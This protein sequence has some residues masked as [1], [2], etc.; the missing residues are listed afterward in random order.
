M[1][2][3]EASRNFTIYKFGFGKFA[4]HSEIGLPARS[5]R[6]KWLFQD[7][8]VASQKSSFTSRAAEAN[9]LF[10][11]SSCEKDATDGSGWNFF[12]K[13]KCGKRATGW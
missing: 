8:F 3:H 9:R 4:N 11:R 2:A 7:G 6:V 1:C 10:L 12:S 5:R 13:R